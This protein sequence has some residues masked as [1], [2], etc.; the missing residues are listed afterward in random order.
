M[1][2]F[3]YNSGVPLHSKEAKHLSFGIFF[4]GTS[5]NRNNTE[6]RKKVQKVD[7]YEDQTIDAN[8][9]TAEEHKIYRAKGMK[10]SWKTLWLQRREADNS[11][12]NDFTN[13]ARLS[14][15]TEEKYTVYVEGIGTE[16]NK[17]DTIEGLALG[18]GDTGVLGKVRKGCR[19]LVEKIKDQMDGA[20]DL[21]L[22]CLTLDVFGFSRG[23]AAARHFIFEVNGKKRPSDDFIQAIEVQD[24]YELVQTVPNYGND[25][26]TTRQVPRYKTIYVNQSQ[27]EVNPAYLQDGK[28][29][30]YGYLGYCLLEAGILSA[31]NL[32]ELLINVRFIGLYDTVSAY[33]DVYNDKIKMIGKVSENYIKN[34]MD[35]GFDSGIDSLQLNNLGTFGK[36]V[37]FVAMDEHRLNFALTKLPGAIEKYLP[38]VHSDIGGSYSNGLEEVII[39]QN[40]CPVK[41]KGLKNK[42]IEECWFQEEQLIKKKPGILIGKRELRKEYSFITLS[43][44]E[45]FFRSV[46][47]KKD[48]IH[49]LPKTQDSLLKYSIN[50]PILIKAQQYLRNYVFG[51]GKAWLFRS[52]AT[53]LEEQQR[54]DLLRFLKEA[55]PQ[56]LLKKLSVVKTDHLGPAKRRSFLP[57]SIGHP[58]PGIADMENEITYKET[59]HLMY[60]IPEVVVSAYPEQVLLRQLRNRFLHWSANIGA[61]GMKPTADWQRKKY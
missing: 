22:K 16:D 10:R 9:A 41:F 17:G 55:D 56:K 15:C 20:L 25:F 26:E 8:I 19:L 59:G 51:D 47:S 1:G 32:N 45:E 58:S 24:G 27:T 7:E 2:T 49:F 18:S 39:E 40:L 13:V 14:F 36:A 60:H 21:T 42:L 44:M 33:D 57:L 28:M 3:V 4:D 5:N 48:Q 53:L 43:F 50:D 29:P 23:A 30:S 12:A 37:H 11:F 52:D 54:K 35:I 6:I 46:L 61:L 34:K 31:N 38:G